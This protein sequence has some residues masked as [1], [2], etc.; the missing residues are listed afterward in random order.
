MG[1]EG[2]ACCGGCDNE[3]W[4]SRC[5]LTRRRCVLENQKAIS[6]EARMNDRI[7]IGDYELLEK[8]NERYKAHSK[9]LDIENGL[10]STK[11]TI[12]IQMRLY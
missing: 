12:E 7:R 9:Q 2:F 5:L 11:H 4:E 6:I 10:T 8:R 3:Y 1:E